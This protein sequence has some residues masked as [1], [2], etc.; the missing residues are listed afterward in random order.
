MVHIKLLL[1]DYDQGEGMGIRRVIAD[2]Q[3]YSDF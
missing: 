2:V 1:C 3:V